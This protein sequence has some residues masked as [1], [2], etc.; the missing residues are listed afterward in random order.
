VYHTPVLLA[1]TLRYL[2]PRPAGLYVDGTVGGG[3]HAERILERLSDAGRLIGIDADPDAIELA[4][5]RLE[6]FGDRVILVHDNFRNLKLILSRLNVSVIDGLLLDL[7]ISSFQL[8][9]A[10]RGFSFR[11]NDRLDMRMDPQQE[12]DAW[13]V[14]NRYSEREL[15]TMILKYGE[16][17]NARRVARKIVWHRAHHPIETTGDL[18]RLVESVVGRRFL[19]KSLARVF[20]AIRIEVNRE[21]ENLERGLRDAISL[22]QV[23]G[24]IVVISYHSLED[25]IVK[26]VFKEESIPPRSFGFPPHVQA[27][28]GP[29]LNI[30]LRKPIGPTGEEIRTNS[31]AR[32]AKLRAAER[33]G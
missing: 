2:D 10:P 5:R 17:R 3:G 24:R 26:R 20:Q 22:L 30:L 16:E 15:S 8:D 1:E 21:L 25:R 12:L 4:A 27:P 7:G 32:S 28:H 6:R 31:R 11:G 9:A 33:I 19:V 14:V 23:G 13:T 18:A 29:R